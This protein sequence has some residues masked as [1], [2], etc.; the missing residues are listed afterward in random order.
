MS[1]KNHYLSFYLKAKKLRLISFW[2]EEEKEDLLQP[3][4]LWMKKTMAR[5]DNS[6]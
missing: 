1:N 5:S 6:L 4:S 2:M 3:T